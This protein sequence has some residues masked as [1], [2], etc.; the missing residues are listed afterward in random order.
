MVGKN[1]E[2]LFKLN[3]PD[4]LRKKLEN[5]IT[6]KEKYYIT[7]DDKFSL[8]SSLTEMRKIYEEILGW[9]KYC[10]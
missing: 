4:E 10:M 1:T 9:K 8:R 5:A 7:F 2:C 3:D 6:K